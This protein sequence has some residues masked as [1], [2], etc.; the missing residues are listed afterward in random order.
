METKT[1]FRIS[2]DTN[3]LVFLCPSFSTVWNILSV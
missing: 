2:T 3:I 1:P